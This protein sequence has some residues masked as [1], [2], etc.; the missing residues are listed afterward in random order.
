MD[1]VAKRIAVAVTDEIA[2]AKLALPSPA[3]YQDPV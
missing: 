2:D 1:S 3:G